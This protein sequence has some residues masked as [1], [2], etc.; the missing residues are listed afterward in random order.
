MHLLADTTDASFRFLCLVYTLNLQIICLVVQCIVCYSKYTILTVGGIFVMFVIAGAIS[1]LLRFASFVSCCFVNVH[2]ATG[3]C[4]HRFHYIMIECDGVEDTTLITE[5]FQQMDLI[6]IHSF[7]I[8]RGWL[9]VLSKSQS[10]SRNY[11]II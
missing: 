4:V 10:L 5:L 1:K 6:V 11:H 8:Y 3:I 2:F 7:K 9:I